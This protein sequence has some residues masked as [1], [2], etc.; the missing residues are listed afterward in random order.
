MQEYAD[1]IHVATAF[2]VKV[3]GTKDIE[4]SYLHPFNPSIT[5]RPP[6]FTLELGPVDGAFGFSTSVDEFEATP[7][8][9]FTQAL[10]MLHEV[11]Q[12]ESSVLRRLF[13]GKQK[14]LSSVQVKSYKSLRFWHLYPLYA[15]LSFFDANATCVCRKNTRCLPG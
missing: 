10:E 9:L 14:F 15:D 13:L 3:N 2:E 12:V 6:L 4:Q 8:A 7:L 5:E 1:F 11:P